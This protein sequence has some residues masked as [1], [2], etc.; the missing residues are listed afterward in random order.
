[1]V[2][3]DNITAIGDD[4]FLGCSNL[5]QVTIGGN[6]TQI[7]SNAFASCPNLTQ[8]YFRGAPA[9]VGSNVFGETAGK[10][11]FYY[12][13]I[14]GWEEQIDSE[15]HWHGYTVFP[16]N[17]I[18]GETVDLDSLY[19]IKVVDKHNQPLGNASVT[20]GDQNTSSHANG[21][22][23]FDHKPTRAESLRIE[24]SNHQ[25]F[26]DEQF[27]TTSTQLMDVIEMTDKPSYIQ[28]I[29]LNNRSIATSVQVL[30]SAKSEQV[31]IAVSGYSKYK[32][33]KYE[34][35]QGSRVI[36]TYVPETPVNENVGYTFTVSAN[37]F[38]EGQ[39]VL[40]RMYT[41]DGQSVASALNIDVVHL[42]VI[43]ETQIMDEF[44][45]LSITI[46][47]GGMGE[48]KVPFTVTGTEEE[49]VYVTVTGRT[50]RVGINLDLAEIFGDDD[51]DKDAPIGLIH[52]MVDNAMKNNVKDKTG[53]IFDLCGYI[54][55]E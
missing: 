33:V 52:K 14:S 27:S 49:M 31:K 11:V 10:F 6:V 35:C 22:A 12:S 40:V 28:G 19:I 1:V 26:I 3:P 45:N 32:V 8:V 51:D 42:A 55:L 18:T 15:G 43:S 41:S 46:G 9:A 7:G 5:V 38:E 17:A 37:A 4:A 21:L 16:Y 25:D 2:I 34:L 23:Y 39:T 13:T 50:I 47:L 20:L 48:Y 29:R 36:T 54:E 44:S 30:D 24:C 53:V